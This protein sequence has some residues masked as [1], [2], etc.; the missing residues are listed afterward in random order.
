[1]SRAD[2]ETVRELPPGSRIT[3]DGVEV[4]RLA[5]GEL[6]YWTDLRIGGRRI[7][8]LIGAQATTS[9][10]RAR[11]Y[12]AG[13]RLAAREDRLQLP[14]GRKPVHTVASA[15]EPYLVKLAKLNG[16]NL[17]RKRRHL[18]LHLVPA[19]GHIRLSGLDEEAIEGYRT[20]RHTTG[21]AHSSINRELASLSDMVS[22]AVRWRWIGTRPCRIRKVEEH[23]QHRIAL[24]AAEV[25]RLMA[26][27]LADSDLYLHVYVS[28]LVNSGMRSSEVLATRFEHVDFEGCRLFVPAA[29]A[30]ARTQPITVALRDLI[31]R[32]QTMSQDPAGW[33]FP[34]VRQ[35]LAGVGHRTRMDR[36][37]ARAVKRAGLAGKTTAHALR[38]TAVTSLVKAGIDLPTIQRISGH[39]TLAMVMQYTH[40][41][42]PHIDRAI[43]HLAHDFEESFPP[44]SRQCSDDVEARATKT[45]QVIGMK[46][47]K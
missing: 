12:V 7:H 16:R 10:A 45:A 30:G 3:L 15:A 20:H 36:S 27:S 1:M 33:I 37:F 25:K 26:A 47:R 40:I 28:F 18:E 24:N 11:A 35:E 17:Q 41:D 4:E 9:L 39:R 29:K 43:A 44:S 2:Q 13:L 14:K 32:E 5:S 8:K 19:L 6:R 21:A 38:H 22:W 31:R 23:R 42:D 34:S 46:A